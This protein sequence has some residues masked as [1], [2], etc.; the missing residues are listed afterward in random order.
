M[1]VVFKTVTLAVTMRLIWIWLLLSCVLVKCWAVEVKRSAEP[2]RYG[3]PH[4]H[5]HRRPAYR[6]PSTGPNELQLLAGANAVGTA[7]LI[8]GV[9]TAPAIN[10]FI[11]GLGK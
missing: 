10:S 1:G 3:R 9:V 5:P 11:T 6:R 2:H 8:T 4:R 7:G